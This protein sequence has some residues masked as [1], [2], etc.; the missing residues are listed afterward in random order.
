MTSQRNME[1]TELRKAR[2]KRVIHL[3]GKAILPKLS[4]FSNAHEGAGELLSSGRFSDFTIKCGG[5]E[6]KVHKSHLYVQSKYFQKVTDGPFRETADH[7]VTIDDAEPL[8]MAMLLRMMCTGDSG[9]D[10]DKVYHAWP[11]LG[12]PT[13]TGTSA[14]DKDQF[15]HDHFYW[16]LETLVNVYVL[17]DRLMVPVVANATAKYINDYVKSLMFLKLNHETPGPDLDDL[18][19]LLHHIY[20]STGLVDTKLRRTVTMTA[21]EKKQDGELAP[22]VVQI[23]LKHEGEL[24]QTAKQLSTMLERHHEKLMV[25]RW[26]GSYRY[27]DT[28]KSTMD[29]HFWKKWK[30]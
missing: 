16:E 18:P 1:I 4:L 25:A 19:R 10:L 14:K 8:A 20:E 29:E 27:A 12:P 26:G 5:A 7:S 17:A 23:I 24:W 6:F 28:W 3:R 13:Y 11:K 30:A 2:E 9:A 21:I 15:L 22:A